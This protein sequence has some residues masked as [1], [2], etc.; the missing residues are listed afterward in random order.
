MK[1]I[2]FAL[3]LAGIANLSAAQVGAASVES[4]CAGGGLRSIVYDWDIYNGAISYTATLTNC[5][6]DSAVDRN[7]NGTI[8][9]NGTLLMTAS[10]FSINMT[11]QEALT[12]S[13]IDTG[14]INC[15]TGMQGGFTTASATFNGS[16]TKNYCIYTVNASGVN[17]LELLTT[18]TFK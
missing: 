9:G 14:S 4:N 15:E 11:T 6:T 10:G 17:P 13:G 1:R 16:I 2:I 7:F 18:I 5:K 12:V 8:T 3:L